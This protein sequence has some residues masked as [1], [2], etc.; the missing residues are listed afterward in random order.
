MQPYE[1]DPILNKDKVFQITPPPSI[2]FNNLLTLP[3]D[4]LT[5]LEKLCRESNSALTPDCFTKHIS[6]D[7]PAMNQTLIAH[8]QL[9]YHCLKGNLDAPGSRLSK[10]EHM[11]IISKLTEDIDLCTEGS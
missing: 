10:A 1:L 9:I 8:L 3:A 5:Q 4:W 7:N 11:V 2:D 6:T